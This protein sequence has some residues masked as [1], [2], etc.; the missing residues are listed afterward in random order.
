MGFCL[1]EWEVMIY[2]MVVHGG[3]YQNFFD[4]MPQ[5]NISYTFKKKFYVK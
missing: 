2:G 3:V 5:K 4:M 1:D